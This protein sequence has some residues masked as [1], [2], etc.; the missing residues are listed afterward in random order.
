MQVEIFLPY[1]RGVDVFVERKAPS[2]FLPS[3]HPCV[4]A[5]CFLSAYYA[6][7]E[8]TRSVRVLLLSMAVFLSLYPFFLFLDIPLTTLSSSSSPSHL[9]LLVT[10]IG[11]YRSVLSRVGEG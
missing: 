1:F 5:R 2:F 6:R 4:G 8:S 7:N 11:E 3:V 10:G 9:T